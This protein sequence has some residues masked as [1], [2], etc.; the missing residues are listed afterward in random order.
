MTDSQEL[1]TTRSSRRDLLKSV[2]IAAAAAS[3]GAAGRCLMAEEPTSPAPAKSAGDV[4]NRH[5]VSGID[6][7]N[8]VDEYDRRDLHAVSDANLCQQVLQSFPG[9]RLRAAAALRC[10]RRWNCWPGPDCCR[11]SIP[12][13]RGLA[14][15]QMVASASTFEAGTTAEPAANKDRGVSGPVGGEGRVYARLSAGGRRRAGS[16]RAAIR[17]PVRHRQPRASSDAAGTADVDGRVAF[18]HR[19]LAAAATRSD[20]RY[21]RRGFVA[22][23]RAGTGGGPQAPT[24]EFFGNGDRGDRAAASKRRPR[25]SRKSSRSWRRL[26]KAKRRAA[27]H[28]RPVR[29]RRGNRQCRHAV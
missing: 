15:L 17:R 1:Q 14:R 7:K 22:R 16:D 3:M 18:A 9:R 4:S 24:Q 11:S 23:R 8:L 2:G 10:T 21:R 13:E 12:S 5:V 27:G 28:A 29:G 19:A 25:S 6:P 26:P 20:Q